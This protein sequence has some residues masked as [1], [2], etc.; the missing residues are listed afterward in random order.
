[1]ATIDLQ[2]YERWFYS[3]QSNAELVAHYQREAHWRNVQLVLVHS[4][5][6]PHWP[7]G[8]DLYLVPYDY[9]LQLDLTRFHQAWLAQIEEPGAGFPLKPPE[10]ARP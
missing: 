6:L 2:A 3:H 10:P 4:P 1:M 8:I 9:P 5:Q 7:N